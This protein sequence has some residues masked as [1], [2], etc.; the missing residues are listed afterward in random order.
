MIREVMAVD[1]V[2]W[3]EAQKTVQKLAVADASSKSMI[4]A[5]AKVRPAA[6]AP[7]AVMF[8]LRRGRWC[9]LIVLRP[10]AFPRR[11]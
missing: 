1:E 7:L 8:T 6:T 3:D 4:T 5:P 2:E 9:P 11:P 10:A